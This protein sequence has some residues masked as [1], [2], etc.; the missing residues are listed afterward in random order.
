ME[1]W[2]ESLRKTLNN[3]ILQHDYRLLDEEV[4]EVS[5]EMDLLI[6]DY[7]VQKAC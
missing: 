7:M 3:V 1:E 6:N 2:L 4:I 5:M